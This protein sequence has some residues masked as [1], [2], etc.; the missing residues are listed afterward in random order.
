M[1]RTS[2]PDTIKHTVFSLLGLHLLPPGGGLSDS[3]PSPPPSPLIPAAQFTPHH[4]PKTWQPA[5][6]HSPPVPRSSPQMPDE[7][8]FCGCSTQPDTAASTRLGTRHWP[9]SPAREGGRRKPLTSFWNG[10]TI[11]QRGVPELPSASPRGKPGAGRSG[12]NHITAAAA[13]SGV[14]GSQGRWVRLVH[15]HAR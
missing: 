7:V 12:W 15:Q 8:S 1:S 6:S 11:S 5:L 13:S 9:V 4:F 10:D 2:E 3:P 14:A